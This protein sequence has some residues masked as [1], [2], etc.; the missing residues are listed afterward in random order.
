MSGASPADG[1][2]VPPNR[3]D[4]FNALYNQL[5]AHL[6]REL[7]IE[8]R[9]DFMDLVTEGVRRG[10]VNPS[11]VNEL[12]DCKALRNL[13]VHTARHPHEALAQPSEWGL[14]RFRQIVDG[15]A[16]P[17]RVYP[18]FRRQLK[19][20]DSRDPFDRALRHMAENDYSQV[21]VRAGGHIAVLSSEGITHWLA[22]GSGADAPAVANSTVGDVLA[23]EPDGSFA[24]LARS[25]TIDEARDLFERAPGMPVPRVHAIIITE[26]GRDTE[27]PLGFA[28][29]WDLIA[30]DD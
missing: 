7:R 22:A 27:E 30:D 6:R 12:R 19:L 28:T 17:E 15:I 23:Y 8:R 24:L 3:A 25:A 29:P 26:S 9:Y 5:D 11:L 1:P 2:A 14:Q 13:L 18:A 21:I 20:F 16:H 10:L 4:E